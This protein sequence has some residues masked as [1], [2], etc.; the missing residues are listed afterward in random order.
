MRQICIL[1]ICLTTGCSHE[2][3]E[4][5]HDLKLRL[6]QTL[7]AREPEVLTATEM[8]PPVERRTV[9]IAAPRA[10]VRARQMPEDQAVRLWRDTGVY[11][12]LTD[13]EWINLMIRIDMTRQQRRDDE[14]NH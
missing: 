7:Q 14:D 1:L 2:P 13:E 4:I 12:G 10:I 3:P 6:Q 5:P 8:E 9:V 11:R